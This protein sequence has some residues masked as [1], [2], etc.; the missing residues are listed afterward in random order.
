V[1]TWTTR[2]GRWP[3]R[4]ADLW[5]RDRLDL[6]GPAG[7]VVRVDGHGEIALG[8]M[9]ASLDIDYVPM[10]SASPGPASKLERRTPEKWSWRHSGSAD[11][12][13]FS[14]NSWDFAC[15]RIPNN[16]PRYGT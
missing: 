10:R 1:K 12:S 8:A 15:P 5:D 13:L 2:V 3:H 16:Q 6:C 4:R 7:L 9:Q 11:L 14:G